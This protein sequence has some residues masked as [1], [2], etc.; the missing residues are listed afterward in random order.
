VAQLTGFLNR[1]NLI[2]VWQLD[3]SRGFH[4]LAAAERSMVAGAIAP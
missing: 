1:F 3:G 4:V 2:P